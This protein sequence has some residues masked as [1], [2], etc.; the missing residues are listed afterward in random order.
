MPGTGRGNFSNILHPW[1][2]FASDLESESE[3]ESEPTG[4]LESESESE[5]RYHDYATLPERRGASTSYTGE[6]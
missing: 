6:G 1:S 4:K 2:Y 3:S 5:Q